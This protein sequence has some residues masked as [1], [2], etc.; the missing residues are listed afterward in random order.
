MVILEY[1]VNTIE[2][3]TEEEAEEK[4]LEKIREIRP[5]AEIDHIYAI[6]KVEE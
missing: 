4:A 2:A 6:T 1:H 3:D 5:H